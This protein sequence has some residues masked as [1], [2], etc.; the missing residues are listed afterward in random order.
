M[1]IAAA[2]RGARTDLLVGVAAVEGAAP[3]D[4]PDDIA[5][6]VGAAPEA[7]R[8]V[9]GRS[10]AV[11]R[12]PGYRLAVVDGGP[13]RAV[14]AIGAGLGRTLALAAAV[15]RAIPSEAPGVE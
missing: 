4:V 7:R 15:A 2:R 6:L 1:E 13:R 5:R 14:V 8:T 11:Y 3:P 12:A 9:A 10:I